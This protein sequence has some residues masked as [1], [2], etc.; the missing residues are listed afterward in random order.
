MMLLVQ[1]GTNVLDEPVAKYLPAVNQL[2]WREGS[3]TS[4]ITFRELASHIGGLAGEPGLRDAAAGPIGEWEN[5]VLS[6]IPTTDI[7]YPLA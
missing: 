3:H 2:K 5:M 4:E 7:L 1:D 6:S